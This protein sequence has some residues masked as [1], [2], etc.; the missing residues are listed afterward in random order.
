MQVNFV[1][2]NYDLGTNFHFCLEYGSPDYLFVLFKSDCTV[3]TS[4]GYQD[5]KAGDFMI[6]DKTLRQE[7]YSENQS[8]VHDYIRF[9]PESDFEH[10]LLSRVK[11]H[12]LFSSAAPAQM[13]AL[14]QLLAAEFYSDHHYRIEAMT[15]L[16]SFLLIQIAEYSYS[17]LLEDSSA[18]HTAFLNLRVDLFSNPQ[19]YTTV[20]SAARCL[21]ISTSHFQALYK[22]YFHITFMQDVITARI[23]KA[24]QLLEQTDQP[25]YEIAD[26]CGYANVSHFS[27]QFRHITGQSPGEYR[28]NKKKRGVL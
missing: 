17:M 22:S 15:H 26:A 20:E 23:Q 24:R 10:S 12:R 11:M 13:E 5:A 3:Y 6:F 1:H 28:K 7:Y 4:C 9:G 18:K 2:L 21:H 14:L 8:F 16:M 19:H 25:N 27:R